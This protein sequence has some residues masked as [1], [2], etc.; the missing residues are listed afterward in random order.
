MKS[1]RDR[2]LELGDAEDGRA[3]YCRA[4]R[5][6]NNLMSVS[7]WFEVFTPGLGVDDSTAV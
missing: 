2:K 3:S 5:G 6:R 7:S 4:Q 1:V